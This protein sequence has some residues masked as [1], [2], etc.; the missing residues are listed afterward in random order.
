VPAVTLDA[1]VLLDTPVPLAPPGPL[2]T[3]DP[4][5]PDALDPAAPPWFTGSFRSPTGTSLLLHPTQQLTTLK[6]MH[7][8]A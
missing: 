8:T 2:A 1:V 4:A 6:I 3:L 5:A 7:G